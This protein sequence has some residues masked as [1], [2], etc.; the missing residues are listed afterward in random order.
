MKKA[1]E[2]ALTAGH[3]AR[4]KCSQRVGVGQGWAQRGP[5]EGRGLLSLTASC[6]PL[7]PPPSPAL[8]CPLPNSERLAGTKLE[9]EEIALTAMN[10][11][12]KLEA[13][14][15]ATN[16]CLQ[17]EQPKWSVD[18]TR[19]RRAGV[20]GGPEPG[21]FAW[22]RLLAAAGRGSV[23]SGLGTTWGLEGGRS[24]RQVQSGPQ[25]AVS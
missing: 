9:V 16:R 12:R 3:T 6:H 20:R 19:V 25:G 13:V 23:A 22:G 21:P 7:L 1:G 8:P 15:E 24:L 14:L 2:G 11:R 18:G 10:Q 5:G 4:H 17:A